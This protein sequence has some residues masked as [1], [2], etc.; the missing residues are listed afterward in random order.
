[1]PLPLQERIGHASFGVDVMF[2]LCVRAMVVINGG[3]GGTK[4][5]TWTLDFLPEKFGGQFH[6][7][8]APF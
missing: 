5:G 7:L 8:T 1:M 4:V 2:E 6:G 3:L